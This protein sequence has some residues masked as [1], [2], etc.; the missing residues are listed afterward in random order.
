MNKFV[1]LVTML[2]GLTLA[3]DE[4]GQYPTCRTCLNI[5]SGDTGGRMNCGWCHFPIIY[6][7][8]TSGKRCAD[9]RDDPWHCNDLFDTYKCNMGWK[10][11]DQIA[12]RCEQDKAGEGFGSNATCN[13]YCQPHPQPPRYKCNVT[14]YTCGK[15]DQKDTSAGC[16]TD[17]AEACDNCE[18]PPSVKFR[19]DRS[20]KQN[21]SCKRCNQG[22][23][24]CGQQK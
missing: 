21:P 12:G 20:D 24:G 19:C 18:A 16:I 3:T 11:V 14:D 22:D 15:C 9:I 5:T 1:L 7:N 17:R 4:C 10:C 2:V 13:Q 6:K 8:G 23:Q